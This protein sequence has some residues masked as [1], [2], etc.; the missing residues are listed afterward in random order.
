[1]TRRRPRPSTVSVV[2]PETAVYQRDKRADGSVDD[3]DGKHVLS[4]SVRLSP[5]T[6]AIQGPITSSTAHDNGRTIDEEDHSIATSSSNFKSAKERKAQR[7]VASLQDPKGKKPSLPPVKV[8]ERHDIR[9]GDVVR[10]RGRIDEWMR[11]KEW[12]RQVAVE[13]QSGGSIRMSNPF[14]PYSAFDGMNAS[15]LWLD[16]AD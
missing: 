13:P 1:M 11:G 12:I 10:V 14:Q 2:L 8:Y 16:E 4:V 6:L 7:K 15:M 9:V 5:S 3:G